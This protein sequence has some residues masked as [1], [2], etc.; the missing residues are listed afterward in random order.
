MSV[1]WPL[2]HCRYQHEHQTLRQDSRIPGST[3]SN[4]QI[5]WRVSDPVDS[6]LIYNLVINSVQQ[7]S[8]E[9]VPLLWAVLLTPLA[10]LQ[11]PFP[12]PS[13]RRRTEWKLCPGVCL[14]AKGSVS[15]QVG[16]GD[17]AKCLA[18]I[19]T[20]QS[21]WGVPMPGEILH[22]NITCWNR[23]VPDGM[24]IQK[25]SWPPDRQETVTNHERPR[26]KPNSC[27]S[28]SGAMHES[29]SEEKHLE[30]LPLLELGN[31]RGKWPSDAFSLFY[32]LQQALRHCTKYKHARTLSR[33]KKPFASWKNK[34]TPIYT[35]NA[36]NPIWKKYV[37]STSQWGPQ[38]KAV[39]RCA[40]PDTGAW[41]AQLPP[42][43]IRLKWPQVWRDAKWSLFTTGH[44]I[45]LL[46]KVLL[47]KGPW[48]PK[49]PL[50]SI[51]GCQKHTFPWQPR[52]SKVF[53]TH[54]FPPCKRVLLL[55]DSLKSMHALEDSGN[56]NPTS[57]TLCVALSGGSFWSSQLVCMLSLEQCSMRLDK[58][59][60]LAIVL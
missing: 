50:A 4:V 54:G 48:R 30:C 38:R 41:Q 13:L 47:Q 24:P 15:W 55:A 40:R 28:P 18:L 23:E 2:H 26:V 58:V 49:K 17:T 10:L 21:N 3:L 42:V 22:W 43:R 14:C 11:L 7:T 44:L 16:N 53:P 57:P 12:G 35:Q 8:Q 52:L 1:N 59:W 46:G 60:T 6:R 39:V 37:M 32:G 36:K 45:F 33:K 25:P 51:K 5:S 20:F 29:I 31:D 56:E 19:P 9:F 34:N 27:A